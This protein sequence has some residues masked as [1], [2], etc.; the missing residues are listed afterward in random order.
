MDNPE[1]RFAIETLHSG[2]TYRQVEKMTGVSKVL[3]NL[4]LRECQEEFKP[5]HASSSESR[6]AIIA[7]P[8]Q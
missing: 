5:E 2:K 8:E 6:V 4:L 3:C 1:L 7:R